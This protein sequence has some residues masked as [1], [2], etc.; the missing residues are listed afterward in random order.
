MKRKEL[1]GGLVDLERL[2]LAPKTRSNLKSQL[3]ITGESIGSLLSASI[4]SQPKVSR[5]RLPLSRSSSRR[6]FSNP[7][8]TSSGPRQPTSKRSSSPTVGS[9][10]TSTVVSSQ[11][12]PSNSKI[13]QKISDSAKNTEPVTIQGNMSWSTPTRMFHSRISSLSLRMRM[14]K[15]IR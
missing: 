3:I 15:S 1:E 7:S 6:S 8:K 12:S 13:A 14:M 2:L 9:H 5:P 10:P 11:S 4:S